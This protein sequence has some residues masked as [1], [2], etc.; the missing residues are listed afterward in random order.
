M[1]VS[2]NT[3]LSLRTCPVEGSDLFDHTLLEACSK[4]ISGKRDENLKD[5]WEFNASQ[6]LKK[7]NAQAASLDPPQF[8][9]KTARRKKSWQHNTQPNKTA[10]AAAGSVQQLAKS[11]LQAVNSDHARTAGNPNRGSFPHGRGGYRG[12]RRRGNPNPNCGR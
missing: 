7:R 5:A 8:K 11:N 6:T 10:P 2:K 12:Q 4:E 9:S 1:A 3:L